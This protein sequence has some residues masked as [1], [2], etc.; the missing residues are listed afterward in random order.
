MQEFLDRADKYMKLDDAIMKEEKGINHPTTVKAD[1]N[2]AKP[3][4]GNGGNGKKRNT[5]GAEQ[6]GE[7]KAKSAPADKHPK[8]QPYQPRFTNYTILTTSRAEIYLATYQEEPYRKPPPLRSE[9]KKDKNKFCRFH[10]DYGHDTNECKQLKDEIEFLL[11]SGKLSRYRV[12]TE[13]PSRNP[14]F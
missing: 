1:K 14:E 4:G 2:S 5:S 3:Q 8:L 11:R 10:N 12:N 7:K 9:G 6:G 13:T